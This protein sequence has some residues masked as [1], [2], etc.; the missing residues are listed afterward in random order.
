MKKHFHCILLFL[1]HF[2]IMVPTWATEVENPILT[3]GIVPQQSAS[4]LARSWAPILKYLSRHSG[5]PLQFKTAPNIPTFEKRVLAG[6][7]DVAYMN[8]YHYTV[9]HRSPGYEAFA[10]QK[11][12]KIQGIIVVKTDSVLQEISELANQTLAF[13]APAAFAASVLPRAY[14]KTQAIPITPK[15]VS[16]HDSV[17]LTVSKGLYPAGG[18]IKRTLNNMPANIRDQLKILWTTNAYTPHA[19]AAHP[20]IPSETVQTI[21]EAMQ[22]MHHTPIGRKLLERINFKGID[23]AQDTDWDDVRAL[24]IDLLDKN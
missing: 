5:Y 11:D 22:N 1:I 4:Q 10:K 12:K 16:S 14:L 17:Y 23:K 8:P 9:Y 3:F 7:Y 15:Y 24:G 20:R 18:G 21:A 2:Y 19:F 6:E 13:P